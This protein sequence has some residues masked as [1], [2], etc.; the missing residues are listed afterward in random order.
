MIASLT[1]GTAYGVV[2]S[3]ISAGPGNIHQYWARFPRIG[4]A[5]I[6]ESQR[7]REAGI[8]FWTR[9]AYVKK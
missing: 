1:A 2:R 4:N 8:A 5:A 3:S 7:I 9:T 6:T